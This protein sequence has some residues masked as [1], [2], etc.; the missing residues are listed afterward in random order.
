MVERRLLVRDGDVAAAP[1]GIGAARLE[2]GGERVGR[3]MR[4]R[5]SASMPSAFSQKPWIS[6]DLECAIGSPITSA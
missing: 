5:Y 6:G 2:I 1:G 3:D 4:A